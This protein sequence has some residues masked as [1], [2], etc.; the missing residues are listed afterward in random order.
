MQNR[1]N[2]FD[3]NKQVI[4]FFSWTLIFSWSL[5]FFFVLDL[6]WPQVRFSLISFSFL[7]NKGSPIRFLDLG[8]LQKKVFNF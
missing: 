5:K 1:L 3:E 4:L 8:A 7:S 6:T 2:L